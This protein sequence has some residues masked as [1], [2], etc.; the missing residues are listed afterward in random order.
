MK[1]TNPG[2]VH[3]LTIIIIAIFVIMALFTI[4]VFFMILG[5]GFREMKSSMN[6]NTDEYDVTVDATITDYNQYESSMGEAP[7][8]NTTVVYCPIYKYEYNGETYTASGNISTS[9]K[10]YEIGEVTSVMI[11]SAEPNKMY[12]PN[13]NAKSEYESFKMD[14]VKMFIIPTFVGV[15]IT[16]AVIAVAVVAIRHRMETVG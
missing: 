3:A 1:K 13:F 6:V 7:N 14:T 8:Y 11:S 2:K 16:A 4:G 12:D 5:E 9:E 10:H 15:L